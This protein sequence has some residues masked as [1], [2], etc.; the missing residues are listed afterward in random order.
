MSKEMLIALLFSIII[1]GCII[2]A[3]VKNIN[4]HEMRI[5]KEMRMDSIKLNYLICKNKNWEQKIFNDSCLLRQQ[6][7]EMELKRE[8][9]YD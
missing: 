3:F 9:G 1:F 6:I 5:Q 2:T 4:S 7:E 8:F